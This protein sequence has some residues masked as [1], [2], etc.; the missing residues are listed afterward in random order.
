[1]HGE[2]LP[3]KPDW[4]G[5]DPVTGDTGFWAP[6]VSRR[7]DGMY[8]MYF[9]AP[10]AAAGRR[11]IGAALSSEPLGPFRPVGDGPLV[12]DARE[13]GDID[14]ASFVDTDGKR[15]LL[16]KNDGNAVREPAIVWLQQVLADGV[17]FAG[18]RR[19]LIRNDH[20]DEAGVIEAPA[21]VKRP[22][23]YVLFY[24]GG[25]YADHRYFTSYAVS[26]SLV[27]PYTKA[28]R[29][30]MTTL[31]LD[32]AVRGPGGADAVG[33]RI[34]FHG[35][36][37]RARWMYAASLGWADDYPVV[38]G[39]RVRY[40]A[41]RGTINHAAIRTGVVGASQGSVVAKLDHADSWVDIRVFAPTAGTYHAH[42]TYAAGYGDAQHTVTVNGSAS[43]TLNYP[44]RGW[45]TWTDVPAT[46]NLTRGWNTLRFR[47][48]SRW[49]ELDHI[50]IA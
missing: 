7:P 49:A 20:P 47:H 48:H 23:H 36:V 17:T 13:G 9:T 45:D 44:N 22:S 11:C 5:A 37:N 33:E 42:V 35:W 40:E 38:R 16:Y 29:P 30:L 31:T 24:S 18:P 34:F 39:S 19:E 43:F 8:I 14:P 3:T 2:A 26:R 27:G 46:L 28:H 50:E 21:L 12:C 25:G 10:S 4:A 6:D 41:E 1:M 32:G 15:Y